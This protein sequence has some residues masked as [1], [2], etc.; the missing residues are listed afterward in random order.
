MATN[1]NKQFGIW[2]DGHHATVVGMTSADSDAFT[3]LAHIANT[4]TNSNASEKVEHHAEIMLQHK[5]FKEIAAHMVNAEEAHVTGT[6][7]AKEQFIHFIA[8]I[9]EFKHVKATETTSNKMS[10][11][12]LIEYISGQFN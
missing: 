5:F 12:K 6:G 3:V 2:M 1:N 11:E 10:D 4:E 8:D 9:P 7:T